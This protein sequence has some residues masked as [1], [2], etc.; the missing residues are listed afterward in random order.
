MARHDLTFNG[1]MVIST[2]QKKFGNSSWLFDGSNDYV[3]IPDSADFD[4]ETGDF[5]IDFWVNFSAFQTIYNTWIQQND[6]V[7]VYWQLWFRKDENKIYF[8]PT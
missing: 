5:T 6:G 2:A 7:G 3:S 1:G 8:Q 4:F